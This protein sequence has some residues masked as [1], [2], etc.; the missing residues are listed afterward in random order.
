MDNENKLEVLAKIGRLLNDAGVTW[1]V[2]ASLLLY[3]MR[4][5]DDFHDID[6]MTA[7][8]DA[9]RVRDILLPWGAMEPPQ[10]NPGYKTRHFMEFMI[11]GVEIDVIAGFVI[12]RDGVDYDCPFGPESIAGYTQ[13]NGVRIP[14]QSPADWRRYYELMGR[15]EKAAL[16]DPRRNKNEG[17]I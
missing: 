4:R 14:L 17:D 2:G 1:A 5:V 8:G 15:P 9:L 16:L 13:V 6:I 10:P 11:D 3:F 12:T 7:D